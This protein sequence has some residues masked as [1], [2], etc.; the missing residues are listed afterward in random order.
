[1]GLSLSFTLFARKEWQEFA[2]VANWILEK[3][4][5]SAFDWPICLDVSIWGACFALRHKA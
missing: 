3:F 4:Q 5:F 2:T 1:M